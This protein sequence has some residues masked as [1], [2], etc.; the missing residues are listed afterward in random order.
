MPADL[1][2]PEGRWALKAN[3]YRLLLE[4]TLVPE[5]LTWVGRLQ[6]ENG[7]WEPVEHISIRRAENP[8]V[9]HLEFC[10]AGP[11]RQWFRCKIFKGGLTGHVSHNVDPR[12][13]NFTFP[14]KGW[15][16]PPPG[17]KVGH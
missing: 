7:A 1:T 15:H 2:A 4:L 6:N 16:P 8:A 9:I 17:W 10:R 12:A 11:T 13:E 3:G 5:S 14:V